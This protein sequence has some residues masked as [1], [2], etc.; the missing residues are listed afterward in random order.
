MKHDLERYL[1]E[2]QRRFER[3]P[4]ASISWATQDQLQEH[5]G[6]PVWAACDVDTHCLV[7]SDR[8]RGA[9]AYVVKHL[10]LHEYLHLVV[11]PSGKHSHPV[12]MRIAE[13]ANPDYVRHAQWLHRFARKRGYRTCR[14]ANKTHFWREVLAPLYSGSYA[15]Y[16]RQYKVAEKAW[17]K[18]SA[19]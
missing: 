12:Q 13:Q 1:S 4:E 14:A 16:L 9:P 15:E 10:V 11:R 2:I 3:S 8:L 19:R 7:I 5:F 6:F 17:S 18:C